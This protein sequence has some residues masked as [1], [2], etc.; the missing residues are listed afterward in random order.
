MKNKLQTNGAYLR[1]LRREHGDRQEDLAEILH[2]SRQLLSMWEC[3]KAQ[4]NM[5][6]LIVI[7]EY[8]NLPLQTV[9]RGYFSERPSLVNT[10]DM[11]QANSEP[12]P[13]ENT[14]SC[15]PKVFENS[16]TQGVKTSLRTILRTGGIVFIVVLTGYSVLALLMFWVITS[17]E[18]EN[19]SV[20]SVVISYFPL[21]A[22]ILVCILFCLVCGAMLI[23]LLCFLVMRKKN[24]MSFQTMIKQDDNK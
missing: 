12:T 2:V 10:T 8:Y 20:I 1:E 19:S 21:L 16:R 3:D 11:A 4:A 15:D 14:L 22:I 23:H 18:R 17:F 24:K 13:P 6:A 9:T 7:S 5:D